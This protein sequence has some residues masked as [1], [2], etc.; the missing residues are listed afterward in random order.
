MA[1][2]P[3]NTSPTFEAARQLAGKVF[4]VPGHYYWGARGGSEPS[5][6]FEMLPTQQAS[7]VWDGDTTGVGTTTV[8]IEVA[9]GGGDGAT[10][11]SVY[12]ENLLDPSDPAKTVRILV[13]PGTYR[14]VPSSQAANS[15]LKLT[16]YDAR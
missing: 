9:S 3:W 15:R 4:G 14:F 16:V 2:T 13:L 11:W 5:E 10:E 12:D 8:Q 6:P 7:V 1:V